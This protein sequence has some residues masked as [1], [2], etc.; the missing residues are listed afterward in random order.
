M[1]AVRLSVS[2]VDKTDDFLI[3]FKKKVQGN[4]LVGWGEESRKGIV[5]AFL[6]G[7]EKELDVFLSSL[8][9]ELNSVGVRVSINICPPIKELSSFRFLNSYESKVKLYSS[10][11]SKVIVD[12]YATPYRKN[13]KADS[14][15]LQKVALRVS[16]KKELAGLTEALLKNVVPGQMKEDIVKKLPGR[17]KNIGPSFSS[18]MYSQTIFREYVKKLTGSAL[19]WDVNDKLKGILFAK[20][21]EVRV[22]HIYQEKVPF[23]EIV[24]STDCVI[25]PS[26][27]SGSIGVFAV[28]NLGKDV[29]E[30]RNNN[31]VGGIEDL[32]ECIE[33]ML[34]NNKIKHDSWNVEELLLGEDNE[35]PRDLKFYTFYGKVGVVLEV[36]R[37]SETRYCFYDQNLLP[38]NAGMYENKQLEPSTISHEYMNLAARLGKKIPAP[39]VR[40]D[41]LKTKYGPVFGEF[42]PRPGRFD[43]FNVDTDR[44]LG[45]MFV[46]AQARLFTD[47]LK[48]EKFDDFFNT[49]R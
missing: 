13:I 14:L 44:M 36:Y 38:F 43:Q 20:F 8:F 6:Q 12:L 21:N 15:H 48:G 4:G 49:L 23:S 45:E 34:L 31:R 32:R 41:F 39:M 22:P 33:E 24:V 10:L 19:E 17:I 3:F 30:V 47:L 42:T 26:S 37:G 7:V 40:I 16:R 29:Y 1:K 27:G 35:L 11:G 28:K 2:G 25:K 46:E 5:E 9:S 18:L